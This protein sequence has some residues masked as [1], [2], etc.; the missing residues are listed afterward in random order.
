MLSV[1]LLLHSCNQESSKVENN[2]LSK[3][4]EQT[5]IKEAWKASSDLVKKITQ[6][7]SLVIRNKNWGMDINLVNDQLELAEIQPAIGKSYSLYFDDTDLN[8]VDITYIPNEKGQLNAINM[9]IF[10]EEAQQVTSLQNSFKSYFDV[11]FGASVKKGKK[12]IWEKNKNTQVELEDA[13]SSKDLG[14]KIIL[15]AKP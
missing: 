14:I 2:Q 4:T 1:S 8:F 12:I 10:V 5:E 3:A 9:D 13:S 6:S 15:K 11:K 7:D